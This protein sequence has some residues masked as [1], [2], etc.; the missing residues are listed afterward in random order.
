M[1]AAPPS[2]IFLYRLSVIS[3]GQPSGVESAPSI[4][5]EPTLLENVMFLTL[6]GSARAD[7]SSV[8]GSVMPSSLHLAFTSSSV[9]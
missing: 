3:D 2:A 5:A 7:V 8:K 9:L 1:M 6:S 4:G